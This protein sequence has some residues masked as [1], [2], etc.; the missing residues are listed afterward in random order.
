MLYQIKYQIR[1]NT[2]AH[3]VIVLKKC[4]LIFFKCWI[5]SHS[6]FSPVGQW[7]R[8]VKLSY[9]ERAARIL[10][11]WIDSSELHPSRLHDM[12]IKAYSSFQHKEIV[13]I[14]K[15]DNGVYI[16]ELFYGPTAS[17]KDLALQLMPRIFEEAVSRRQ[18][19]QV[20]VQK[21]HNL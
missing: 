5:F 15:L 13:P 4:F 19:G 16:Q 7:Q 1:F 8:L 6:L 20:H 18:Q 11:A 12:I 14:K 21:S 9:Q 2:V 17:F 3:V 10:E